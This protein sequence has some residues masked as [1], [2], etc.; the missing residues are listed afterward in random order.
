MIPATTIT[1]IAAMI[2][3]CSI[4]PCDRRHIDGWRR[5]INSCNRRDDD[6]FD[7]DRCNWCDGD[8]TIVLMTVVISVPI[9]GGSRSRHSDG[10]C[11]RCYQSFHVRFLS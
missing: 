2:V 5:N 11:E 1:Y 6:R 7:D 3:R 10:H 4:D 9:G 8:S